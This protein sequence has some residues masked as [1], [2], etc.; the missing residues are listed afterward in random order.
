MP[1]SVPIQF[2]RDRKIDDEVSNPTAVVKFSNQQEED[3]YVALDTRLIESI[4]RVYESFGI[5]EGKG[6]HHIE[7]WWR[8]HLRGVECDPLHFR[9]DI[10]TELQTLLTGA[11]ACW[12]IVIHYYRGMSGAA[13][14]G[15]VLV[16]RDRILASKELKSYLK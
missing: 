5:E 11:C 14:C 2:V 7:D 16:L 3:G 4:K 8:N 1:A 13:G 15:C 6:V 9:A 12:R 10:L